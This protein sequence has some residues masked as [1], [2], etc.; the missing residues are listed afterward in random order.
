M[1]HTQEINPSVSGIKK[2]TPRIN[3]CK[4][5]NIEAVS[6]RATGMK[7]VGGML[8]AAQRIMVDRLLATFRADCS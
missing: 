1:V 4:L 8:C 3:W 5:S 6:D 7:E 2:H